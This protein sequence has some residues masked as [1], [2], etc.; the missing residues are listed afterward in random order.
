MPAITTL[1][2][3]KAGYSVRFEPIEIEPGSVRQ[4]ERASFLRV[5]M[6]VI[7]IYS[8]LRTFLPISVAAFALGAAYAVWT[9]LG[10]SHV[11][12]SSVV[13]ILLSVVIFLVGL[14]SEQVSSLRFGGR[15]R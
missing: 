12:N 6:N 14:I 13:L 1:A 3:L 15:R 5:L 2:F 10:Q 4:D 7:T 11:T 8:P 9:I